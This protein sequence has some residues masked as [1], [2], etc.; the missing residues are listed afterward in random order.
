MGDLERMGR[1]L[2]CPI[3]WSLFDSAVSLTCNHH[4]CNSCIVKSM[5]SA[6]ACPVCKIPFTRRE[7]RPA[8]HMDNLVNI[9][10]SMEVASGINIFVT[11]N[12]SQAKLSD[13]EKQCD[14]SADFG[15]VE[16]GGSRKG[17][18]Q[19]KKTRK[20]KKAKKTV[21]VNMESSGSGLPKP[22]FPAKKRVL[23]PQNIL[24][25]TPMKNLKLGDCLS[26]INKEKG[27]QK[28]PL[29]G[30]EM[31][32]QSEKSVPVLSPFFWLREEKDGEKSSPPTD[33][34]QFIDGSTPNPPSFSDLRDSDDENTSNVAPFDEGQNQIS[35]NLFDSEMFE[36]TQR[37]CSPELF[38]SPS[39]MQLQV[40]DTYEDDENQDELVAA[41]QELDANLPI[42]DADNMKI[43][44]PKGNKTA[45]ALPPN[46]SPLIRSSADINGQ[47]K[48]RKR[49]RKAMAKFRHEQI[50]EPK[51]SIDGMHL[52]GHVSLEVTQERALDCKPK[53]CNLGKASRRGKKVCFNTRSVP[54][55]TSAC[56]VPDTSGVLSIDEME[57]V[58]NSSISP[59]KQEN[60][61][62]CPLEIAGKSQ[63]IISG[64]QIKYR[65]RGRKARTKIRHEQIVEPKNS[66]D[67]M[68]VDG[69]VSL[70]VTQERAL[71]CKLK[72]CNLGMASRRGKKVCFDT[73]SVPTSTSACTVPD[74]SG[75]LSID[76]MEMVANPCI[77]PSKQENEKH[78]PL[79][80][81]G[82][83]QKIISGK[84]NM[85]PTEEFAG[86]DSSLF[87]LQTNSNVN[88]SKSKQSKNIFTR[89]SIS[90]SKKLRNT[91]RS[92]LSS[93]CTSI[94]KNA[95][96]ILPNE[97]VH[98]CPHVGDL[99]DTSKEKHRSLTDKT[100]LRKC[101]SHVEK[102]QC[103]FCLSSEESEVS[104]PMVHYLD[105]KP[106]P[107]DHEGGFKVTHC[108][109][110]CTE[111]APNVYFDGENAI[112]LEAEI[113][114]S[115]RIKCS[116]CGLKG[117]ALG[118]Y[119]KSCRRSFHVPCAKWTSLCRW[120]TQNFVMLC[121]LHASSMLPCE[122]SGS[123]KRSKKGQGRDGKNHGPSLDTISQT[124]ADHR[125]YKKIV[126]CCSALSV[127]EKDIVSKFESVSKV[128][129]L[130]NWDSSVTHVIAST[131]ENGACRR[132]LKVL[133][134]ILEGKWIVKV[135]WIKACMK[136]MNPVGEERYETNVDI[137]GIRD[138]PRLGRL[139]VLNK[140][141]KLFYGYKFY[142]MGDFLP[143]Y[144]GYLQELVVAAG[145]IIL[146]RKPV[147]CDQK[148]ML[149]DSHSYQNFIVYSLELP[150]EC[151]PSEMDT[152]CRQRCHDAEVVANSTGSKV[153]TNTW[154][155]NS[156]AACKLQCLA[157]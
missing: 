144:K 121:P 80:I 32:L 22:S 96:E 47:I 151:K 6:S 26:E 141:P 59:S 55:S 124:R 109:R 138:G 129:I 77:S 113:S 130:K 154:I 97:S 131:D 118:C 157:Q 34:D 74:S 14:G 102:Y 7:I 20:M 107:A 35:V 145:G 85:N 4:F 94:T 60:E 37:P 51:N 24:S 143:S 95:E 45:D 40:M 75:V 106:V 150:D 79:E 42:T 44:N 56:T 9:Y 12:V 71:D 128:T 132:T 108:H 135:E 17:H 54:T 84:Q 11:Q 136:E 123:Q 19:E 3:C 10:T 116:F 110:N 31:P 39:K 53:S 156:I 69:H 13:V 119:E 90:G 105:G 100:V 146:H 147:S 78:C 38:S 126:L 29:I 70:E 5:K 148:S 62:H 127:Q 43:E 49:G 25:E 104:G 81:A 57:M 52:V 115:R 27:V 140:Q 33:E 122:D 114:R 91:E 61:K 64:K 23:V 103:F 93:E 46:V 153:V 30:S 101:E 1:E 120:D 99:N 48:S 139:R 68:H 155:L 63:K 83:I 8:P 28:V 87:S 137:H 134:G 89:K 16:A 15:K 92:K 133:L 41:S 98:H 2:K 112:N 67:G 58:A 88:T 36:W 73:S 65:K 72:S 76:E 21:Q 142:F 50:V 111:W 82:K 66:I 125:S 18:V 152:I 117:A 86:S 149:P